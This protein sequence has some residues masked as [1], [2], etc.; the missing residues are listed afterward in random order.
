[1]LTRIA[2]LLDHPALPLVF[3]LLANVAF[4]LSVAST[5]APLE[6]PV[7]RAM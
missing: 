6:L 4:Y 3:L 2:K 7:V 1:M 5:I